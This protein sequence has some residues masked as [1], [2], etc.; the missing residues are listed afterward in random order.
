MAEKLAPKLVGGRL[1]VL[2][3]QRGTGKTQIAAFTADWR[4]RNGYRPGLY[5]RA[6]DLC[7]SVVG[8]DREAKLEKLQKTPFLVIDEL[9]RMEAKDLPLI[10]S[11]VDD[12]YGNDRATLCIG[13]WISLDGLHLGETVDGEKLTGLG[14]SLFSRIQEHQRDRT[15]GVVWCKWQSYRTSMAA[16][17]K[18]NVL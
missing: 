10:E 17:L 8:F 6:F 15:G 9:H 3:G 13:N 5:T 2:A 1:C 11:V 12:R 18:E 7:A 14:S 16:E 4:A